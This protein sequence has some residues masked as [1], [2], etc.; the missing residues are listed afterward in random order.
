VTANW[1]IFICPTVVLWRSE[2]KIVAIVVVN[3]GGGGIEESRGDFASRTLRISTFIVVVK[4][5]VGG[6]SDDWGLEAGE[7]VHPALPDFN[8]D[9]EG[10]PVSGAR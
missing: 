5:S 3:T 9:F 6:R 4:T 1:R 7:A 8:E 2:V 10:V